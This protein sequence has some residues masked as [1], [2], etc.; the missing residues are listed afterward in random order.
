MFQR[1]VVDNIKTHILFS[2]AFSEIR[3]VYEIMCKNMVERVRSQM[4]IRRMRIAYW[5]TKA[6]NTRAATPPPPQ[7][8]PGTP[9]CGLGHIRELTQ[10]HLSLL[11]VS[12]VTDEETDWR[13]KWERLKH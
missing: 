7:K 11:G 1:T 2:I 3:A 10:V 6:T 9:K 8:N 12:R 4:T 13:R 5:I